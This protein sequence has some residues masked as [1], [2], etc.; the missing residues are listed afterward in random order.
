MLL[1]LKVGLGGLCGLV[2][3][4]VKGVGVLSSISC[5]SKYLD[6]ILVDVDPVC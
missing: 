5:I 2:F 6:M 3:V 1:E 4:V